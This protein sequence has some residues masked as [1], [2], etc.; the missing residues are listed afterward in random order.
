L[1][2]RLVDERLVVA[3]AGPFHLFA[4]PVEDVVVQAEISRSA[5]PG[6]VQIT[7]IS[8]PTTSTPTVVYL[9][10]SGWSS[11]PEHRV[12]EKQKGPGILQSPAPTGKPQSNCR[13]RW[14]AFQ[15]Q[16]TRHWVIRWPKE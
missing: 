11:G 13:T 7:T 2:E 15:R 16:S 5:S 12:P 3:T 4:E 6:S 8:R 14:S 9:T 10:S 1:A